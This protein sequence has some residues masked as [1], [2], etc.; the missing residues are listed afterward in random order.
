MKNFNIGDIL[1]VEFTNHYK[2]YKVQKATLYTVTLESGLIVGQDLRIHANVP[3]GAVKVVRVT[4]EIKDAVVR[5][6]K[7][8]FIIKYCRQEYRS[9]VEKASN[10]KLSEICAYI[11]RN[12]IQQF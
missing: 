1:A 7:I 9:L 4:Q 8:S 3:V 2:I 11:K 10:E 5:H 12:R 6:K